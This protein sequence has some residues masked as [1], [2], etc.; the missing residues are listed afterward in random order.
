MR[1][2]SIW[3]ALVRPSL[4]YGSMN[5]I[6]L[7]TPRLFRAGGQISAE[8]SRLLIDFIEQGYCIIEE[9]ASPSLIDGY[10]NEVAELVRTRS[11]L[12]VTEGPDVKQLRDAN[13]DHA[14]TKILDT[15]MV[16]P[17]ALELALSGRIARMMSLIF[18]EAPFVHQGLHFE[19]G[20]TQAI[21]QDTAYVVVNPPLALAAAW[22]ALEDVK[23]GSGELMYYRSSHRFSDF[24][25]PVAGA[26][27]I[28]VRMVIQFT[29]ITSHGY[30]KKPLNW[31]TSL[32]SSGH[33]REPHCYGTRI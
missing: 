13:V 32:S 17:L 28:R 2:D 18:Q 27:G 7:H 1:E 20:S 25:T 6:R 30:T 12:W 29:T 23:S 31:D 8:E 22:L 15:Y 9:A 33:V 10:R 11:D 19:V 4:R 5:P 16:S 26:T 3:P 14:L 24:C 21:H